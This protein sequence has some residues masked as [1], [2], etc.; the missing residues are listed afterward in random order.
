[1]RS[2]KARGKIKN[3]G[4][5]EDVRISQKMRYDYTKEKWGRREQELIKQEWQC[6]YSVL[7]SCCFVSIV[8]VR[9]Q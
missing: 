4:I 5:R 1:M 2:A 7:L 3:E 6:T 9:K 8:A